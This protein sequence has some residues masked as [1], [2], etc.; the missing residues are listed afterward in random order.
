MFIFTD[1]IADHN[2]AEGK[3]VRR[4]NDFV[5]YDSFTPFLPADSAFSNMYFVVFYVNHGTVRGK[6]NMRDS[7]LKSGNLIIIQQ[8]QRLEVSE[9]ENGANLDLISMSPRFLEEV[10]LGNY[11]RFLSCGGNMCEIFHSEVKSIFYG[12]KDLSKMI[13]L[14]GEGDE[15][16]VHELAFITTAFF[17][18]LG[19]LLSHDTKGYVYK[20]FPEL[21]SSFLALLDENFRFHRDLEWYSGELCKSMK[22]FSRQIKAESGKNA[23]WWIEKR[24]TEEAR[25]LLLDSSM[26]ISQISDYLGFPSQ[27]FF[28][29][30]FKRVT[31]SSPLQFRKQHV[32]QPSFNQETA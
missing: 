25:L 2:E 15:G 5:V 23:S 9:V 8:K 24:V 18:K 11:F 17:H 31:G 14:K 6:I 29:K 30:Y 19:Q 12:F 26:S 1:M 22:Y 10:D 27:S 13:I 4:G 3:I 16:T 20:G 28:G 32:C 7:V 21:T